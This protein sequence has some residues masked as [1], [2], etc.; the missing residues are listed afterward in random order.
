MPPARRSDGRVARGRGQ[1]AAGQLAARLRMRRGAARRAPRTDA[2]GTRCRGA[3]E[4]AAPAPSDA[5]CL[6]AQFARD[7][8]ARSRSARLQ[9]ARGRGPDAR[10][11][12]PAERFGGRDGKLSFAAPA[13][14]DPGRAGIARAPVQPRA[15]GRRRDRVYRRDRAQ[16]ARGSRADGAASERAGRGAAGRDDARRAPPQRA[17]RGG[18]GRAAGRHH[19]GRGQVYRE[20]AH[21]LSP[22]RAMGPARAPGRTRLGLP[23]HRGRRTRTRAQLAGDRRARDAARSSTAARSFV[24]SMAA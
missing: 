8:R 23:L 18:A 20:P 17:R 19:A 7:R 9:A 3:Q 15:G 16:R 22:D 4:S 5:P 12:G 24:S 2:R 11:D 21:R 10:R 14:R 1:D 13:A 6:V